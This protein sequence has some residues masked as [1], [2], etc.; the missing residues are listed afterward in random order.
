MDGKG[1]LLGSQDPSGI[2]KYPA[3]GIIFLAVLKMD[4]GYQR[5]TEENQLKRDYSSP[6]EM[7]NPN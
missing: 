6:V 1:A 7:I 5:W 4:L 3:L 2:V